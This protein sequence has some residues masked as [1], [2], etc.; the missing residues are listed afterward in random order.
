MAGTTH[1]ILITGATGFIGQALV[2]RLVEQG[3][4]VTALV[5]DSARSRSS[6]PHAVQLLSFDCDQARLARQ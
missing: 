1:S 5:R 2:R 6:L 4:R 3:N